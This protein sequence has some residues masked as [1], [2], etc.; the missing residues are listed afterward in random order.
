MDNSL[1]DTRKSLLSKEEF[2]SLEMNAK[3]FTTKA[4]KK[5]I[6]HDFGDPAGSP[7]IF[8]H[9]TGSHIHSLLL[10][11]PALEYGFRVITPDRPGV[12]DSEFYEWE[13][14]DFA[15]DMKDLIDELGLDKVGIM[16]LSGGGPTLYATAHIMPERLNFCVDLAC[17]KPVYKD[18]DM[19]KDLGSA[20]K[21][22]AKVG[23]KLP[24]MLFEI[25]YGVIGTM[26]KVLKSPKSFA[27]MFKESLCE[28]DQKIF[29]DEVFQY[30]F[31]KDFSHLF[32]HGVKGPAYDAKTNYREWDFDIKDVDYQVQVYHGTADKFVPLKFSQWLVGKLKNI[33]IKTYEGEG[34]FYHIVYGYQLLKS[35]K[36]KF[37]N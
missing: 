32:K 22:Y 19:I 24:L 25:P 16:G 11:K 35:I 17:A 3:E 33:D 15:K 5:I 18:K 34:H 30:L 31:M 12:G 37:F 8:F 27:K 28:A 14:T 29:D 6:Y 9:G 23:A 7:I 10:H 21:F 36:E 20:D 13:L 2:E 1:L 26:Q 4:G